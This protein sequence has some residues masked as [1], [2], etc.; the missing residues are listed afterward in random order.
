MW[1]RRALAVYGFH[2]SMSVIL[3]QLRFQTLFGVIFAK[4]IWHLLCN[5]IVRNKRS[6]LNFVQINNQ[7]T[8]I[9][10][11]SKKYL[12]N[13]SQNLYW[14]SINKPTSV[15]KYEVLEGDMSCLCSTFRIIILFKAFVVLGYKNKCYFLYHTL[16]FMWC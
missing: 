11:F 3:S 12:P 4:I 15:L 7:M 2:H 10:R 14:A 9:N 13:Y 8:N 16:T 5:F 1:N 6:S